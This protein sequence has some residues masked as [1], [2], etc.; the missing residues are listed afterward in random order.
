MPALPHPFNVEVA[1]IFFIVTNCGVADMVKVIQQIRILPPIAIARF[2]SSPTPMENYDLQVPRDDN[3]KPTTDFRE[4]LPAQTLVIDP[5][6]GSV[7]E[8][9][10]PP[11][12]RFRD[13]GGR[14]KPVSPFLEV[15]VQFE[16]SD[17]LIPLTIDHL[18]E[19]GLTPAA[20][21]WRAQAA[22]RKPFRRTGDPRDIVAATTD[23]FSD[24]SVHPLVGLAPNFKPG[25]S[26]TL[27]SVQYIRPT[28]EFPD[29]RV[30]FTP[31]KGL[32]FGP[33]TNDP[34]TSDDVYAGRTSDGVD[35][36]GLPRG[37]WDR[38]YIGN[39]GAPPVTA[40][41][42][43]FQGVD[44]GTT[45][46]SKLS[47]GYFDDTCDGIIEV[48]LEVGGKTFETYG[49]IASAVPDFAPDSLPVRSIID[50]IEQMVFGPD[51]AP[52]NNDADRAAIKADVEDI[53]RR[54]LDTVRHINTMVMNGDEPVADVQRNRNNMSGQEGDFGRTF[55]AIFS[56]AMAE[57][58]TAIG[59][60]KNLLQHAVDSE[61]KNAFDGG[62]AHVR[63]P[64]EVADLT[65]AARHKMPA[66]MRGN[67][68]S[69]LVL[70]RRQIAKL[71]L[72]DSQRVQVAALA[73]VAP[74]KPAPLS[75]ARVRRPSRTRP[76][77]TY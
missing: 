4:I 7:A 22:N 6:D 53:I 10:I 50:D 49:R 44:I 26:I 71:A 1:A 36:G 57:Y 54:A 58:L 13:E 72:A 24:H 68:G 47:S 30:R 64:D 5:D 61:A 35:F 17:D 41:G 23:T 34:L 18:T 39:P 25:K 66:M 40:P 75:P 20:I 67:E 12:I 38:Y 16:G 45:S 14:I 11:E 15:W 27:G 70:T 19:L 59:I 63:Q 2:G 21:L 69:E 46:D 3:G 62:M 65:N 31:G 73:A 32:V 33:H 8:S 60:H 74:K 51:V 48:S 77:S 43:I 42:D 28:K 76:P 56:S 29:I 37:R 9:F 55:E 52:P